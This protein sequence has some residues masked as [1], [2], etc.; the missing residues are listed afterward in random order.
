[1]EQ[2]KYNERTC[3]KCGWVHFAVSR[4]FAEN[5]VKRFN[6]YFNTLTEDKQQKYYG[7]KSS[8]IKHYEH[9]SLCG[10]PYTNF[11]ESEEDD[12]PI[13]VTLGPIIKED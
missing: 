1:M 7:G 5:E 11:R 12:C 3:N 9:C 2:K 13:G 8:S 10:N 6:D 4:E